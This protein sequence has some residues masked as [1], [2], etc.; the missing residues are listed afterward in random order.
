[1]VKQSQG[2]RYRAV[3][4]GG[5]RP[6]GVGARAIGKP[7]QSKANALLAPKSTSTPTSACRV[8]PA[9]VTPAYDT[10]AKIAASSN[11]RS[12][13][14]REQGGLLQRKRPPQSNAAGRSSL[15]VEVAQGKMTAQ[16]AKQQETKE[17]YVP[18]SASL[19]RTPPRAPAKPL[20]GTQRPPRAP[21]RDLHRR[22]TS[23]SH[24]LRLAGVF[25]AK[26]GDPFAFNESDDRTPPRRSPDQRV[27]QWG[28][29]K[30]GIGHA[31]GA[32]L[33]SV[34]PRRP[35]GLVFNQGDK[36]LSQTG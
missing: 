30:L 21:R 7:K 14:S 3:P 15:L 6:S 31:Q 19:I 36:M 22:L 5:V 11:P 18:P 1:M 35:P 17:N 33:G 27:K 32:R 13:Y 25:G 10:T 9:T 4:I 24:C 12:G 8:S 34:A 28:N 23:W 26:A 29:S 20:P 2:S 16:Q